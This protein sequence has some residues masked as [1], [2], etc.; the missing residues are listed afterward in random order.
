MTLSRRRLG[1]LAS[2]LGRAAFLGPLLHRF[3]S[4]ADG[5]QSA[6]WPLLVVTFGNGWGH[7]GMARIG[8]T[9][10]TAVRSATDWDLPSTLKAF[11]PFKSRV[12]ILRNL[13]NP[14]GGSLHGSGWSTL[15]V[16]DTDGRTPG[17]ISI[18]R[19][20]ALQMGKDDAF[21][22]LSLG[23]GT[24]AGRPAVTT[25]ADGF[26][27]PFPAIASPE[28]A[29][30]TLFGFAVDGGLGPEQALLDSARQDIRRLQSQ[31]AGSER[32]KLE[33]M[34]QSFESIGK[35]SDARRRVLLEKGV[36]PPLTLSYRLGL[37]KDVI[38][39]HFA[40]AAAAMQFGLTRVV[41]ISL[42]GFDAFNAGWDSLGFPGDAHENVAHVSGVTA[43]YSTKAYHAVV[44]FQA[45]AIARF[46]EQLSTVRV[47][48]VALSERLTVLWL[49]SGGGKHHDGSSTHPCVVV[50][51]QSGLL[52]MGRYI[53][54][55][56]R[57]Q[58]VSE[59]FLAVA[60]NCGVKIDVFGD[61]R[62][63]AGPLPGLL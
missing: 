27:R 19:L 8:T 22:S 42:L 17:G 18:D 37:D 33:Q 24:A 32:Q 20:V 55:P 5:L 14:F 58:T 2:N 11:E 3:R 62:F 50:G 30:A 51:P 63:C 45:A 31:L 26:R 15:T 28:V 1:V 47:G 16:A 56:L 54:Y 53:D 52:K 49:N 48:G 38:G 60:Q 6:P 59:V 23:I 40:T 34:L 29:F 39:A 9:L 21:P 61:P 25:S 13:G 10:D 46:I 4:E 43:E 44:Q 41:H 7:Q 57:T 36:P 35:Q 12:S